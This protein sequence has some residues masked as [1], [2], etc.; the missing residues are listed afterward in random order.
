MLA[1]AFERG[2]QDTG[3]PGHDRRVQP[4]GEGPKEGALSKR[5]GQL[6]EV[7]GVGGEKK[8]PGASYKQKRPTVK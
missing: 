5:G 2:L 8:I 3:K 1:G 4:S 7:I 6:Q